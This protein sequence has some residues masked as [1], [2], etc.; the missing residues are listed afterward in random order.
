MPGARAGRAA[1]APA[2]RPW[3]GCSPSGSACSSGDTDAD[4]EAAAGKPIADIFVDDGE[5]HFRALEAAAVAAALAGTTA[6]SA[7]GGGAVLAARD[8]GGC[9]P[10]TR[11]CSWP[12]A[13]RRAAAGSG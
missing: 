7:L 11:S 10:G 13:C 2:R 9:W 8:R 12:S 1:G 3:A 6:C 5:E 4:I